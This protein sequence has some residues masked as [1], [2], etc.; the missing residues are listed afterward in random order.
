M[1]ITF[2]TMAALA[3]GAMVATPSLS[4]AAFAGGLL[5]PNIPIID[6]T[7]D[8]KVDVNGDTP[9]IVPVKPKVPYI[10][11]PIDWSQFDDKAAEG[12]PRLRRRH[13]LTHAVAL[14]AGELRIDAVVIV[15]A[16]FA[17]E[18][19]EQLR[20]LLARAHQEV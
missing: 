18:Q 12:D 7:P 3:L 4:S 15:R 10:P 13:A 19:V 14:I 2:K 16:D 5:S 1:S 17:K 9:I 8:P 20:R 6:T 11:L